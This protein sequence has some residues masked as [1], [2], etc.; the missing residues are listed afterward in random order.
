MTSTPD[1]V[2]PDAEPG[3][4]DD[5]T[6]PDQGPPLLDGDVTDAVSE[7]E[8]AVEPVSAPD[9]G[10][11]PES[12]E[13]APEPESEPELVEAEAQ[14][15]EEPEPQP[16]PEPEPE[17]TV[18]GVADLPATVAAVRE[19][20]RRGDCVVLPTDTVYGI[21]ADA[22]SPV[23]VQKLLD[24]KQRGRDMPPPVLIADALL[25][26]ALAT[27]IPESA[28]ALAEAHWP[29]PL[30]LILKAHDSLRID[31]GETDGTIAV[32]VPDNDVARAI[33]RATGPLAVSS[34]NVSGRDPAT[35][36]DEA[37]A[38]LRSTVAVY[39]DGGPTPGSVPSTI[40][41][42]SAVPEGRVVRGGVL[43]HATLLVTAPGLLDGTPAPPVLTG[44]EEPADVAPADEP[45][46]EPE[47][48]PEDGAAAEADPTVGTGDG[49]V[50]DAAALPEADPAATAEVRAAE[51][52]S[53]IDGEPA[54]DDAGRP[55]GDL[56]EQSAQPAE[57]ALS[58]HAALPDQSDRPGVAPDDPATTT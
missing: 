43:D 54:D 30:T 7:P 40:V 39:V 41:D 49:A 42:F 29:G 53:T 1:A 21:G 32:R 55:E 23:A 44:P 9:A 50:D 37:V 17:P 18:L 4:S 57:A 14:P 10:E 47:T 52:P 6:Q 27:E 8:S 51:A 12:P 26:D 3:P 45:A 2:V 22:F 58:A 24:A 38:Q 33:L 35:V 48:P 28:R 20:V 5:E 15:G 31:L 19:A 16:E 34:A 56:S 13:P 36:A 46:P 11:V 25:L